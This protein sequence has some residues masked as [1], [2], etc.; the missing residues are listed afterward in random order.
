MAYLPQ[1]KVYWKGPDGIVQNTQATFAWEVA[2]K[3]VDDLIDSQR[4]ART[5]DHTC[6]IEYWISRAKYSPREA[7]HHK[8]YVWRINVKM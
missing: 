8:H 2:K 3:F 7:V 1:Y 5:D 6:Q 4:T